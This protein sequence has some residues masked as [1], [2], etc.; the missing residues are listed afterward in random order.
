MPHHPPS[1]SL[2]GLRRAYAEGWTPRA[3]VEHLLPLWAASESD[4]VWIA[5]FGPAELLARSAELEEWPVERRGPLW[6][7]PFAVKDNIDVHGLPTTAACPGF[8][9]QPGA[10]ATAVARLLERGAICVGKANLD[11][12][13]T[14]LVGVRTPHGAARNPFAAER[15]P[16][17]SSS[18]SAAAVAMGL[19][20]FALGT[21]TAGSGRIPAGFTSTVGLKPTRGLVPA[22]GVV[23]ACRSLD[24]VSVFAL[25]VVDA[26]TVL[27]VIAGPDGQDPLARIGRQL[28]FAGPVRLGVPRPADLDWLDGDGYAAA[29]DGWLASGQHGTPKSIDMSPLLAAA[30]LLYAGPWL[31][32]RVAAV[33]D[34]LRDRAEEVWPITRQ[35]IEGGR[36]FS[37]VDA[38]RGRYRIAELRG[39]A[40]AVFET[41]DVLVVPTAPGH[42]TLAEVAAEPLTINARLGRWTN[43]VNLLD[44]AAVAVPW[45]ITEAG[46]PFGLTL[47]APAFHD[48]ALAALAQ[49]VHRASGLPLGATGAPQAEATPELPAPERDVPLFVVGAHLRGQPLNQQLLALGARFAGVARTAPGYRLFALRVVPEKPGLARAVDAGEGASIE[50]EL[51]RLDAGAFGQFVAAVPAP[52]T[53]GTVELE[54]GRLVKG[55]GCESW[56]LRDARD[57]TAFGGW[58]AYLAA[59]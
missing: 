21:D 22:S 55:F 57:I 20:S 13:A 4:A 44:L 49:R 43:F 7:V 58:R 16:G 37:A 11:Q 19:A 27:E 5:R 34:F 54:D 14:G 51:W 23:P 48:R 24:C 56:A 25:E 10:D 28:D 52:M 45:S 17:G 9:Y 38:F 35:I 41:I 39:A 18:G 2:A 15:I 3:L 6:G 8:A 42:P 30:D 26:M 50:G 1:L 32:E 46:V 29:W 36:H 12:F 33:G 53:I 40:R 31:A 47:V 59:R